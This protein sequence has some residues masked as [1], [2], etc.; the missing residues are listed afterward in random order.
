MAPKASRLESAL[1][2]AIVDTVRE[3][4]IVLDANSNVVYASRSFCQVFH[5]SNP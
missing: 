2:Q 1:A 5:V 4:L 3:P